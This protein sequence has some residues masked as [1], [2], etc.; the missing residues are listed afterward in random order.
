MYFTI[1]V[2]S[3][4][5]YSVQ[6]AAGERGLSMLLASIAPSAAA[7]ADRVWQFVDERIILPGVFDLLQKEL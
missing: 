4:R 7:G 5:A 2:K 1:F 6:A 3:C